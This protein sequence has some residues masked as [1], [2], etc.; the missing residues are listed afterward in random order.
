MV[1]SE[2]SRVCGGCF[3]RS[4]RKSPGLKDDRGYKGDDD[5]AAHEGWRER[6]LGW[7]Y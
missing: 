5:G 3:E 4:G 2:T 7:R 6:I 1:W